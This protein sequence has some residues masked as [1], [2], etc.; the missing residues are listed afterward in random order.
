MKV[1][2]EVNLN[3]KNFFKNIIMMMIKVIEQKKN[4]FNFLKKNLSKKLIEK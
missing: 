2:K 3:I 1:Y 4:Y